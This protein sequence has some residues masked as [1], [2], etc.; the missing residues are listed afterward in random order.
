MA[1][2]KK[3]KTPKPGR[4]LHIVILIIFVLVIFEGKMLISIFS[5]GGVSSRVASELSELFTGAE[6]QTESETDA[7]EATEAP[8][9]Q[10]QGE[11]VSIGAAQLSSLGLSETPETTQAAETESRP[12]SPAVVPEQPTPVDESYFADATFIGDSR[13]EGFHVNSGISQ[14]TFLTG[15]GM[16]AENIFETPFISTPSGELITV[17]QA[18]YNTTCEKFYILLGTN[19]LGTWNWTEFK[20]NYAIVLGELKK[21][22]PNGIFYVI[23][24]PYVEESKVTTGEYVNNANVDTMNDL[25]IE[26]CEEGGYYY[27]DINE[28]LSNGSH[29]LKDG[30]TSDGVHL[31]EE[32]CKLWLDY[33]KS[34]YIEKGED[35]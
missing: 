34:H 18:L 26:I 16:T 29:A 12:Q 31:Y 7:A 33:L 17:F 5:K 1:T 28:I 20:E 14:G 11:A 27:L 19:D 35:S 13:M 25:L 3:R 10:S 4:L 24:V 15:V 9:T 8:E 32:Y 6:F 2:Q 23:G 21:L 30:A 22:S